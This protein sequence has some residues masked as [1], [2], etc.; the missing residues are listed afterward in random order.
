MPLKELFEK[1]WQELESEG[2][3]F[4]SLEKLVAWGGVTACG[5]RRS[6]WRAAPLR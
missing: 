1:D 4:S 5:P 2:I 3:L 6:G